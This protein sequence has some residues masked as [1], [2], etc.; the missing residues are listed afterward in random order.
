MKAVGIACHSTCHWPVA[1]SWSWTM[2]SS[3]R[4]C[5]ALSVLAAA[6]INSEPIGLRFCGMVEEAPRP[7]WK[8]SSTSPVSV[9]I[10][11]MMS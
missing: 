1:R 9:C 8:G 4:S 6:S 2:A 10:I 5:C 3:I 7:G 11:S